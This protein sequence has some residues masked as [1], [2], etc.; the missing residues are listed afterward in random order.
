M[1]QEGVDGWHRDEESGGENTPNWGMLAEESLDFD[2]YGVPKVVQG[3]VG[4]R[5]E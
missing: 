1:E 3:L 4:G 2:G 5:P